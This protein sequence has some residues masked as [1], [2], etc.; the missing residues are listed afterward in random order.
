MLLGLKILVDLKRM[1]CKQGKVV[2]PLDKVIA[3]FLLD[4][5]I[6]VN[7]VL[8]SFALKHGLARI[9]NAALLYVGAY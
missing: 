4:N 5:C 7:V 2:L 6:D 8:Q 3:N 1:S 9:K